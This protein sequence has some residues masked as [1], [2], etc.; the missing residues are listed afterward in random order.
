M[1]IPLVWLGAIATLGY[2][3]DKANQARRIDEKHDYD[4][5]FDALLQAP[6]ESD[7]WVKPTAGSIVCCRVYGVFEHTGIVIDDNTIVELHGSGLIKAVSSRRFLEDRSGARIYVACDSRHKVLHEPEAAE[8]ASQE[9]F[10]YREYDLL[11]QNCYRF[12]WKCLTGKEQSIARF[13][14][15][16]TCLAH[17]FQTPVVWHRASL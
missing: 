11:N 15:L 5:E 8:R 10:T 9:I 16:N 4:L 17:Y 2:A 3:L 13:S 12:C 7:V 1:P 6:G 14:T